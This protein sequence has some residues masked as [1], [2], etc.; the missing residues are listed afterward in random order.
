MRIALARLKALE[1]LMLRGPGEFD[2]SSRGVYSHAS[3]LLFPRPSTVVGALISSYYSQPPVNKPGSWGELLDFYVNALNNLG[4]RALRGFYLYYGGKSY[5]PLAL[6]KKFMLV[7]SEVLECL[8]PEL[9]DGLLSCISGDQCYKVEKLKCIENYA[10]KR[11]M[12]PKIVE[13]V[14]IALKSRLGERPSKTTRE[15]YLYT[16]KYISYP[17]PEVEVRF[18]LL[19]EEKGDVKIPLGKDIAIK[20][21]GEQRVVK[22]RIDDNKADSKALEKDLIMKKLKDLLSGEHKYLLLT[23]PAPLRDPDGKL[24]LEYIGRMDV[25]GLGYSLAHKKRKPLYRALMEG[26]LIKVGNTKISKEELEKVLEYGIY[27]ILELHDVE[28][29]RSLGRIGYGTVIPLNTSS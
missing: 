21:G 11:S 16:A 20:L 23:T 9:L 22:L 10:E 6:G 18:I 24:E 25:I 7:E 27:A 14:G 3:S 2:P 12:K 29:Y 28:E 8:K 19:L 4:I 17:H 13:R 26:T 5:V 1:P 15:G